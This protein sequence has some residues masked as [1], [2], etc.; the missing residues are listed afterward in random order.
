MQRRRSQG[1]VPNQHGAWAIL[2][3]PYLAAI[4]LRLREADLAWYPL[5]LLVF[6]VL[7]Y[8]SFFAASQWLKSPPRRRDAYR[9]AVLTYAGATAGAG[10]VTLALAGPGIAAWIPAFLPLLAVAL[11]LAAKRA[12]RTLLGGAVTVAAACLI[13]LV[14]TYPSPGALAA[15]WGT[16]Q[17]AAVGTVSI[18]LFGYF[19][20]TVLSVKT[21]IRERGR[22]SWLAASIAW[23]GALTLGFGVAA[24]LGW[25]AFF[26]ATTARAALLPWLGRTRPI[27]ASSIGAVEVVLSLAALGC[28]FLT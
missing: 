8:L 18:A 1:W 14:A 28:I 27:P 17:A 22:P 7:G 24:H 5:A 4:V 25:A 6:W 12:E 11:W 23:H 2:I 21:M 16:R 3:G 9:P 26:A 15:A 13:T 10:M 19:F 20:G